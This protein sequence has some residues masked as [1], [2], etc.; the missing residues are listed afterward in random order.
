MRAPRVLIA[1]TAALIG[2]SLAGCGDSPPVVS[3]DRTSRIEQ[4][5]QVKDLPAGLRRELRTSPEHVIADFVTEFSTP[6]ASDSSSV[7]Y[8]WLFDDGSRMAGATVSHSFAKTGSHEVRLRLTRRSGQTSEIT[9]TVQVSAGIAA[10]GTVMAGIV[11]GGIHTCALNPTSVLYCWGTNWNGTIGDGT[12]ANH[13]TP[14]LVVTSQLFYQIATGIAHNC[15]LTDPGVAYCWGRNYAGQLGDGTTTDRM[16]PTLVAGGL[17]FAS[18][19]V[20]FNH[21]CAVT[22]AG[23][24]YCWGG[25][26]LGQL[27]DGTATAFRTSPF[28]VA[29]GHTYSVIRAGSKHTCA[30]QTASRHA[31]CWGA[32]GLGQIGNGLGGASDTDK[33]TSPTAVTGTRAYTQLD[34]GG[35]HNCGI[36][37]TSTYC[38]GWNGYGQLGFISTPETCAASRPCARSPAAVIGSF[39]LSAVG[40]GTSHSCGL[41]GATGVLWCWGNNTHGQIGDGTTVSR[42]A[43]VIV[44]GVTMQTI[45]GGN[46]FTCGVGTDN[47]PRCW[48]LNIFGAL[49]LGDTN[50]RLTPTIVP[51]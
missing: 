18:I 10:L 42:P 17:T 19:D 51:P 37:G 4:Q 39:Q 43:A 13:F 38:W 49:G 44:A 23:A 50:N 30:L 36:S 22:T 25:N 48:G 47:N 26:D 45:R 11:P 8:E 40:L 3:P 15:A 27:G 33:V 34:A 35:S 12:T 5:N 46:S 31:Y 29:A 24:A 14:T 9:K 41:V 16:V 7:S 20:G 28:A 32:S 2:S 21:S 6:I 1:A